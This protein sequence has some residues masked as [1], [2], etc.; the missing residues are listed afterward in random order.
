MNPRFHQ[1][2]SQVLVLPKDLDFLTE[3]QLRACPMGICG[4]KEGI[5]TNVVRVELESGNPDQ[6]A[7]PG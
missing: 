7:G 5:E 1:Y 6:L 3:V 2:T 4:I